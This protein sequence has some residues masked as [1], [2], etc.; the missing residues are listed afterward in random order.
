MKR[1]VVL[2]F[3]CLALV[4]AACGSTTGAGASNALA[5]KTP[6][7]VLASAVAAAKASGSFHYE[8]TAKV[9][10]SSQSIVGDASTTEGRQTI[11][12]G[13]LKIQAELIRK[14][15]Y[16]EGNVGGLEDQMG[17]SSSAASTYAGKWIS[18]APTDAPYASVTDAVTLPSALTELEPTG[19]LSLTPATTEAGRPAI[20]VRGAL[21][22]SASSGVKG[23]IVLYVS[24]AHPTVA[25]AF[26]GQAT[27]SGTKESDSGTFTDWGKRLDLTAPADSVAFSSL[28]SSATAP[29][30]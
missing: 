1:N 10:S 21:P 28:P 22:E 15:V 12:E 9:S 11:S 29:S 27:S 23:T 8:L 13:T 5:H 19:H 2:G 20:G 6:K 16:I 7:A 17:F 3:V 26:N 18:I 25:L 4:S 30:S 14:M 24:T